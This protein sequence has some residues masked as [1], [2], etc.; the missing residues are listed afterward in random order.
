LDHGSLAVSFVSVTG[1][2][3]FGARIAMQIT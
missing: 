3:G 2:R 1:L